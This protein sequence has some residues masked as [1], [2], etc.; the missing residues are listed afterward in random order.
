MSDRGIKSPPDGGCAFIT[1]SPESRPS[2]TGWPFP[3]AIVRSKTLHCREEHKHC[4]RDFLRDIVFFCCN[5]RNSCGKICAVRLIRQLLPPDGEEI[6][7]L[8]LSKQWTIEQLAGL[9]GIDPRTLAEMEAGKHKQRAKL[10]SVAKLLGVPLNRIIKSIEG[11]KSRPSYSWVQIYSDWDSSWRVIETA[12]SSVVIIDSFFANE[13]GR[14][15]PALKKNAARR[16]K[17]LNVAVYMTSH[18][19]EFGA[20]RM[21]E[22]AAFGTSDSNPLDLFAK[23]ITPHELERYKEKLRDLVGPIE[24]SGEGLNASVIAFEYF[25]LPSLRI[26]FVDDVH[27]F[28]SW[29]PMGAQNPGHVCFYLHDDGKLNPADLELCTF[30]RNHIRCVMQLSRETNL[31]SRPNHL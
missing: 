8:R 6:K 10:E 23:R 14:L 12:R 17:V 27:F 5:Y 25:C 21:R 31:S 2:P 28:W 9:A 20:Q 26:I 13:H 19:R 24:K 22:L 29:F 18:E 7:R 3:T 30:L 15:R 1:S 4:A 11:I 16:T